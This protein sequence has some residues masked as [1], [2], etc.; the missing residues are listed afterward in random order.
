MNAL[1]LWLAVDPV[2]RN[3]GCLRVVR[4]SHTWQL[5]QL[6]ETGRN[7]SDV[8]GSTTHTDEDIKEED[9]FLSR[10]IS[11]LNGPIVPGV[12]CDLVIRLRFV[13]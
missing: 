10:V 9:R 3:N 7:G 1:T 13:G 12:T 2:D 4:G 6:T 5:G 11:G 8:L